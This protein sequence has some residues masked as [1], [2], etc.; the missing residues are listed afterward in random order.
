MPNKFLGDHSDMLNWSNLIA[1][2]SL[3]ERAVAG[4]AAAE[5]IAF[6]R[7]ALVSAVAYAGAESESFCLGIEAPGFGEDDGV[8]FGEV[9]FEAVDVVVLEKFY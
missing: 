1:L 6:N 3:D 4:F 7:A 5:R 9:F 2:N 8:I